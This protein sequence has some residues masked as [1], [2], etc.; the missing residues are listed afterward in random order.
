MLP[1]LEFLRYVNSGKLPQRSLLF[2]QP[3]LLCSFDFC[4]P[5]DNTT[6]DRDPPENLGQVRM[7]VA[8]INDSTLFPVME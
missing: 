8:G 5:N 7:L 1:K 6:R 3:H 2:M 4:M